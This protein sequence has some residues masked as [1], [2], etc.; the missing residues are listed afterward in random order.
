M[1]EPTGR[2]PLPPRPVLRRWLCCEPARALR[3]EPERGPDPDRLP[4]RLPVES[5]SPATTAAL[6]EST[7]RWCRRRSATAAPAISASSAR[8]VAAD[9]GWVWLGLVAGKAL[10]ASLGWPVRDCGPAGLKP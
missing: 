10:A 8:P 7:S 2:E 6:A 1:S 4:R 9:G 3:L 5:P